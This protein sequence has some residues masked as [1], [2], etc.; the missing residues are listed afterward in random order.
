MKFETE[1]AKRRRIL[2]SIFAFIALVELGWWIAEELF[3]DQKALI[4]SEGVEQMRSDSFFCRI[5][6]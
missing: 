5:S 2:I 3:C 6:G 1:K 4:T